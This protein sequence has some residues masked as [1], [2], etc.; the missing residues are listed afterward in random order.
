MARLSAF[1]TRGRRARQLFED[2]GQPP[3][4]VASIRGLM[5]KRGCWM[6]G[7]GWKKHGKH[8]ARSAARRM[9]TQAA[10]SSFQ[11]RSRCKGLLSLS[12][13]RRRTGEGLRNAKEMLIF[14]GQ[15]WPV[16]FVCTRGQQAVAGRIILR[17]LRNASIQTRQA[18]AGRIVLS[19]A[20][21][22]AT[23]AVHAL[24]YI[25][26]RAEDSTGRKRGTL[27]GRGKNPKLDSQETR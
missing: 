7:R 19:D 10:G 2:L 23:R 12:G 8:G 17:L 4:T 11:Q 16:F 21:G 14:D 26:Y 20:L 25:V 5:P 1:S 13:S 18:V 24:A 15:M 22:R 9:W 6:S 3:V 27:L